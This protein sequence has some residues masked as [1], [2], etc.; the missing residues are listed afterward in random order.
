MDVHTCTCYDFANYFSSVSF[1]FYFSTP[2]AFSRLLKNVIIFWNQNLISFA[3][4]VNRKFLTLVEENFLSKLH[5]WV[6][7]IWFFELTNFLLFFM[8][9][10]SFQFY[11]NNLLVF[12][13]NCQSPS[14]AKSSFTNVTLNDV[15]DSKVAN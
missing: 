8:F 3:A 9:F 15:N 1:F 2:C 10:D 5:I 12:S 14:I 13:T 11:P 7:R 6:I 4:K